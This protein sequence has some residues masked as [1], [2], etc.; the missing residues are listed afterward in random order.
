MT[1][2]VADFTV[3]AAVLIGAG[4]FEDSGAGVEVAVAVSVGTTTAWIAGWNDDA[5]KAPSTVT[6]SK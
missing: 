2:S 6:S 5:M 4:V 3:G 1:S